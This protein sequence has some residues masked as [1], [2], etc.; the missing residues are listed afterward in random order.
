MHS[1]TEKS[2]C[3]KG[4][5]ASPQCILKTDMGFY[6]ASFATKVLS[7]FWI[8]L[9]SIQIAGVIYEVE[10]TINLK[11]KIG[12]KEPEKRQNFG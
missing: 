11:S 1:D 3:A 2:G 12:S 4:N 5:R 6:K 10:I 7:L 9:A 8:I